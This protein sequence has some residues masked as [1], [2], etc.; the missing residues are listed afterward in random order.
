MT[1]TT[2]SV[3]KDQDPMELRC[4]DIAG[5]TYTVGGSRAEGTGHQ[6]GGAGGPMW[7][8]L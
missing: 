6:Q 2:E 4:E 7:V 5:A 8:S 1:P 3:L